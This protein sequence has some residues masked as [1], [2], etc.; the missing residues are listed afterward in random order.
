MTLDLTCRRAGPAVGW[1][2]GLR[3]AAVQAVGQR[4][5]P[6]RFAAIGGRSDS[7]EQLV[8]DPERLRRR[9]AAGQSVALQAGRPTE[10]LPTRHGAPVRSTAI[11]QIENENSHDPAM[12]Q[13]LA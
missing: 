1:E 8:R 10:V 2:H 9:L 6:N 13:P 12:N 11:S 3:V 7:S 5:I 4:P